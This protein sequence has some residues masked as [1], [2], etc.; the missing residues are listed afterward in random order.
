[1]G[2]YVLSCAV[3]I[4]LFLALAVWRFKIGHKSARLALL[5]TAFLTMAFW[6][7]MHLVG[8]P[9]LARLAD[10]IRD[11]AWISYIWA[12]ISFKSTKRTGWS[13]AY[14]LLLGGA[15]LRVLLASA[16]PLAGVMYLPVLITPY[17]VYSLAFLRSGF[18]GS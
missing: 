18:S 6:A 5:I 14:T 1:M 17:R 9:V 12:I 7:G 3:D 8:S 10:A 15:A 4:A 2:F 16:L 13:S 11:L